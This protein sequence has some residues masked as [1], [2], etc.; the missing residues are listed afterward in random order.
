MN[1][2]GWTTANDC[3]RQNIVKVLNKDIVCIGET[4]LAK[5]KTIFVENYKWFG[6]NREHKHVKSPVTHGGVGIL[7]KNT[8][9]S[10]YTASVIDKQVDGIL[11]VEFK[12][13]FF[14]SNFIVFCCYLPPVNSPWAEPTNFFG[15]LLSQ[16]YLH[17]NADLIIICGDFNARIGKEID[18]A[19]FDK[20]P[21]RVPL[22]TCK[23]GYCEIFLDFLKDSKCCVLNGRFA[24][25]NFTS[26][27]LG[28]AVVDYIV[29]PHDCFGKYLNF[30]VI[31][32]S[33]LLSE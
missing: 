33:E 9:L 20:I 19:N 23:N 24:N 25:D 5:D 29:S 13:K 12:S 21:N 3:L 1:V 14:E 27:H 31:L 16:L 8:V 10:L 30:E 32:V 2:N 11:G 28:N 15:H 26:T 6:F 17:N 7:V 4:H 22:D 18:F